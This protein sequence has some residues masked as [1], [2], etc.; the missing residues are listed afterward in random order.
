MAA[1]QYWLLAVAILVQTSSSYRYGDDPFN[2]NFLSEVLKHAKT[3]TPD[4]TFQGG[5][6]FAA[7][8]DL[9]G[10]DDGIL[11]FSLHTKRYV[12]AFDV[13]IPEHFDAREKWPYCDSISTI[14]DQGTC[15]SC[16]AVAAASVMSDRLCIHSNGM[17]NIELAAEDLMGCCKDCGRGCN[18]GYMDGTSFQYWVDAGL[19]SG[20][21]YNSTEGCKPY[22]FK[23]CQY[24]FV[25]CVPEESPKCTHHC[26]HEYDGQYRKD[27]FYGNSA[28]KLPN[29]ERMIQLEIM[30]NGPV[31][32][33]FTVYEDMYL[34]RRGVY[35]YVVGKAVGKHAVRIIGWGREQGIPYW[36]ISNSYGTHWGEN[37][38]L[39][40][41]RG[42]NHLD[43]EA[44]VIAGLPKV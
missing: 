21:P 18:G 37:G 29:D 14:R 27:K 9:E 1:I 40:M 31:E 24:P 10:I 43:I 7:F 34:Y 28:Y 19:V 17:Y 13:E 25:G 8:R 42:S 38:Y 3:W 2:D 12:G 39:K 4:T 23:P 5:I 15:G 16:W 44:T 20:A 6:R 32:S 22:P 41:L 35:K 26:I 33:G 11:D 36:L 30:T